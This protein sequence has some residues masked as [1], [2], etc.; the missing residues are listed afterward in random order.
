M[1][2]TKEQIKDNIARNITTNGA[3]KISGEVMRGVLN[4]MTDNLATQQDIDD[5]IQEKQ[6]KLISGENIKTI[7]NESILGEGD[8]SLPTQSV[9]VESGEGLNSVQQKG[10]GATARGD[11]AVAFGK[12]NASNNYSHAEGNGTTAKG[13]NSHAEG[14][15]TQ[16]LKDQAHAEGSA[17]IANGPHSHAEGYSTETNNPNEHAEGRYNKSNKSSNTYGD[18]G[19]TIHSVGVGTAGMHKNAFEIMQNGDVYLYHVGDYEGNN[20]KTDTTKPSKTL[21]EVVSEVKYIPYFKGNF[22]TWEEVPNS[23]SEYPNPLQKNDYICVKDVS[24]RIVNYD[25]NSSYLKG[26]M[27]LYE[28]LSE[29]KVYECKEAA[30]IGATPLMNQYWKVR[31]DLSV[32]FSGSWRFYLTGDFV[33]KWSWEPQYELGGEIKIKDVQP[34]E[35]V[36][37]V[38]YATQDEVDAINIKIPDGASSENKMVDTATMN[39]AL[40]EKVDKDGDKV[41][42][43]N[44]F[45]DADKEK[46]SKAVEDV[47]SSLEGVLFGRTK[48]HVWEPVI[49]ASGLSVKIL[50][51]T[52][53]N[54]PVP[55]EHP[56]DYEII[57]TY[58]DGT[59]RREIQ[60][61][62]DSE[63]IMRITNIPAGLQVRVNVKVP[64]NHTV[65]RSKVYTARLGVEESYLGYSREITNGVYILDK[66]GGYTEWASWNIDD[67]A[68]AIGV[69]YN[70]ST[71]AVTF[72]KNFAKDGVESG[73]PLPEEATGYMYGSYNFDCS[74]IGMLQANDINSARSLNCGE[75]NVPI[76]VESHMRMQPNWMSEN[77][78]NISSV[79]FFPSAMIAY[80]FKTV[81]DSDY[82]NWRLMSFFELRNGLDT[83]TVKDACTRI[84][85]KTP[86]NNGRGTTSGVATCTPHS[87]NT[88]WFGLG[89]NGFTT[90]PRNTAMIGYKSALVRPVRPF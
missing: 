60:Y 50:D 39:A 26:Q 41:L 79:G 87:N 83:Q 27:V 89:E 59:V 22:N 90:A 78:Q 75:V 16:A 48:N 63:G 28:N 72:A 71:L 2:Q 32:D 5:V 24:G 17:T 68:N 57:L 70:S 53:P 10:T 25:A 47:P 81:I 82:G 36:P 38:T 18:S 8:I 29:T 55:L 7:N 43:D 45:T 73:V 62:P 65:P 31:E 37:P 84:G 86:W 15:N 44:N 1:S 76:M 80:K 69:G 13:N 6:D 61:E 3:R 14:Y 11:G 21:Q 34:H 23:A 54:N 46:L 35:I 58:S 30:P 77:V 51:N 33:N 42:S 85:M 49:L 64:K 40:A 12:S 74:S 56:E 20:L 67:N 9:P 88:E 66:F 19:N 52:D 4:N